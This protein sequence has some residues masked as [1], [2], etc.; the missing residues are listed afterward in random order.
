MKALIRDI[1]IFLDSL[2]ISHSLHCS[3]SSYYINVV[4]V[5]KLKQIRFSNHEGHKTSRNS[6]E[7][8]SDRCTQRQ[9]KVFNHRDI[10][11]MKSLLLLQVN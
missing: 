5:V 3:K 1:S 10:K 8:R 9:S 4:G 11:L 7:V 2:N 6:W